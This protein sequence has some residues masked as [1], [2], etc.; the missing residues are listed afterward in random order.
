[1]PSTSKKQQ[2][3][4]RIALAVKQGKTPKSYS[5]EAAK[6]SEQMTEE[7]LK[8]FCEALVMRQ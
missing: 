1:M 6:I 8:E 4:M 2:K 5:R 3:L 7:Q